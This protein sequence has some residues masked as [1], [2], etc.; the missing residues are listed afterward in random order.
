ML[1]ILKLAILLDKKVFWQ[2]VCLYFKAKNRVG[3][4]VCRCCTNLNNCATTKKNDFL[5]RTIEFLIK[6]G[7]YQLILI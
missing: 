4:V 3:L 6:M 7:F 2:R 5:T 1:E